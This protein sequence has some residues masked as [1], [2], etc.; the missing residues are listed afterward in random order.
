[1][2]YY[3]CATR[4]SKVRWSVVALGCLL[5]VIFIISMVVE[6]GKCKVCDA[7][8]SCSDHGF[9]YSYS[10][11]EERIEDSEGTTIEGATLEGCSFARIMILQGLAV[12]FFIVASVP[13]C[14]NCCCAR[15]PEKDIPANYAQYAYPTGAAP[16]PYAYGTPAQPG[17][18]AYMASAVSMPHGTAPLPPHGAPPPPGVP[19]DL[20]YSGHVDQQ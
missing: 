8:G 3:G 6:I 9:K 16:G 7:E 18:P 10:N 14:I 5:G 17:Q 20:K 15:G 12:L 19:N 11:G 4:S 2:G 1:M 13:C